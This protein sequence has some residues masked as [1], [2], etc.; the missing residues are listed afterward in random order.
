MCEL[1][2]ICKTEKGVLQFASGCGIIYTTKGDRPTVGKGFLRC[3]TRNLQ[4]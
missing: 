3:L 2:R 1:L 4:K